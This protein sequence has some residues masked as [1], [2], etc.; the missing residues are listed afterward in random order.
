MQVEAVAVDDERG[1]VWGLFARAISVLPLRA[2]AWHGGHVAAPHGNRGAG[3]ERRLPRWLGGAHFERLPNR[4]GQFTNLK[5]PLAPT[6]DASRSLFPLE[7]RY[8]WLST[9]PN[10]CSTPPFF[11]S[12]TL[13]PI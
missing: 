11:D 3:V 5:L 6:T 8:D 9:N 10:N 1:L 12:A 7:K 4:V 13:G 2:V